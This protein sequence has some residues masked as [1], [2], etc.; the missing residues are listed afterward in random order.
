VSG[1][2]FWISSQTIDRK[3]AYLFRYEPLRELWRRRKAEQLLMAWLGSALIVE[4]QIV[5]EWIVEAAGHPMR[6]WPGRQH[7][8]DTAEDH[9]SGVG[10]PDLELLVDIVRLGTDESAKLVA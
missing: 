8:L 9:L 7:L 10:V 6:L 2:R 4:A 1:R 5:A 3:R